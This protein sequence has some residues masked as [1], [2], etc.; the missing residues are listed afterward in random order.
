MQDFKGRCW[1]VMVIITV[2]LRLP[3]AAAI[4]AE[5]D[6]GARLA[7]TAAEQ[8]WLAR[9]PVI[10]LAP[11]PEFPPIEFIDSSGRYR[12]IAADYAALVEQKLGIKFTLV[13]LD[14]W[15]EVLEKAQSRE[16]D[17]FGAASESPQRAKYMAFT[18][19][20]IQL[21]GGHYY[22]QGCSR[23]I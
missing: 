6:A 5:P 17:M 3:F 10:R 23:R 7:L 22:Q 20:H 16:I 15:D 18:R 8:A 1:F 11:D 19:P 4:A 12:G 13:R 14:S 21:P 9:H 2:L